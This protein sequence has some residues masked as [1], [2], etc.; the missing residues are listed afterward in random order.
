MSAGHR[1][2]AV[3]A[4]A[5]AMALAFAWPRLPAPL[6]ATAPPTEFS[7]ERAMEQLR[8][9][10]ARP[11]PTGTSA[12]DEVRERIAAELW[13]L[14]F[15]VEV[16]D[17]TSL[18]DLYA[19]R[20]GT[21]VV[22]AHV[23]NVI[24]RRPG[25]TRGPALMLMAHYDS[26]ELAPG[27]GD[28]GFGVVTLL[29]TA[30]ALAASPPLRHD[31]VLLFTE[32][33]EQG[34]LG[35]RAF[36]AE[37]PVARDVGLV[38]NFDMRGDRGP[39]VMFQTSEGAAGLVD[40]MASAAPDVFASSLSQEV[41]RRMPN[42]TDLTVAIQAGLPSMNFA[43]IDGFERYHQWTDTVANASPATVQHHGSYALALAR[44]F[45]DAE[46]MIPP[47][48]GDE[49]Y[50]D[51]GP[52][53]VHYGTRLALPLAIAVAAIAGL[54]I[55]A[56]AR[57]RLRIGRVVV[58]TGVAAIAPIVAAAVAAGVGW[59][60][61]HAGGAHLT[62]QTARDGVKAVYD[63][64][65]AALGVAVA[66]AVLGAARARGVRHG[67]LAA[68]AL[69]VMVLLAIA[70]AALLPGGSFLFVWPAAAMAV[71][72]IWPRVPA[73]ALAAT[74]ALMIVVP[75]ARQLGVTFGPP[76]A[77]AIAGIA[78]IATTAT[79]PLLEIIAGARRWS[80]P[81]ALGGASLAAVAT[82]I[83]WPAFDEAW[84]GP[85]SLLYVVDAD[86]A[87]A[88]WRSTDPAPDAWTSSVLSGATWM[89]VS[90][91]FQRSKRKLL[92][93]PAPFLDVGR[94]D[95][96][97]VSDTRDGDTRTLRLHVGVAPGTETLLLTV[98]PASHVATASV[99]GRSFSTEHEDGWLDLVYFGPPARGLEV[100]ITAP[101]AEPIPLRLL[102]QLRGL[103]GTMGLPARPA[104]VMP[105]VGWNPLYASD[106]TLVT[107]SYMY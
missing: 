62:M 46:P 71:A 105:A 40:T 55:V 89:P 63:G 75:L 103:P 85:D 88:T 42:D 82:A 50:F 106:M 107:M 7:A 3:I 56:G 87:S 36:F 51:L 43:N 41:Y 78:A 33:E 26:R 60:A 61:M 76:I 44:A 35:A 2:V 13:A 97:V 74:I 52:I 9:I 1:V 14:D 37:S 65:V 10:A 21:S 30:R 59:L 91:V 4:A 47:T 94:A 5:F 66:W 12:D 98:P 16:Q 38:L 79:F 11:H 73:Y 100:T 104:G 45:G 20:F 34:L 29:E 19:A 92:A 101:A 53:F 48:R 81:L 58:A 31:V 102:A 95:V 99:E 64:A 25:T 49:V 28:D 69:V 93:A 23:R 67:E 15:T 6:A 68:G 54:A 39:A 84:P 70:S 77:P 17:T 22:A 90:D 80:P 83:A 72:A 8:H 27:A 96:D 18:T 32:G 86:H 24:A 57:R